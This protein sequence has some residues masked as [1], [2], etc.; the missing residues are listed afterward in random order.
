MW[1]Y[2]DQTTFAPKIRKDDGPKSEF[3]AG[4]K[5][6]LA[7]LR[8]EANAHEDLRQALVALLERLFASPCV[9]DGPLLESEYA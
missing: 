2:Q 5:A 8:D 3:R 6:A 4:W 7:V 1:T 9:P